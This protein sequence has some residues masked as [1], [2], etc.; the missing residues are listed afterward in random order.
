MK[1]LHEIPERILRWY[2][3]NQLRMFCRVVIEISRHVQSYPTRSSE[4]NLAVENAM[5]GAT[6][7]NIFQMTHLRPMWLYHDHGLISYTRINST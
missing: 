2:V 3:A 4:H 6:R 5:Y 7:T 1:K